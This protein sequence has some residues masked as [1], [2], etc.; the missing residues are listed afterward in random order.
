MADESLILMFDPF[1]GDF[2]DQ[3]DRV[4]SDKMVT[5]RKAHTCSN[6]AGPI[7]VGERHRSRTEIVDGDMM[8]H[9]WCAICCSLMARIAGD[10]MDDFDDALNEYEARIGAHGTKG[11]GE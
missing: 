7:A 4:L 5:G 9:R 8:S 6:C 3:G 11:E 10:D 2:G 1:E